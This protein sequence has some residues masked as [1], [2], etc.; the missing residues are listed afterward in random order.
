MGTL[1]ENLHVEGALSAKTMAI[2]AGTVDNADVASDADIDATKLE[3][4]YEPV[5]SQ[6]HGSAATAE[7]RV[8]HKVHG[9]TGT[10]VSF[11]CGVIVACIGNAEITID[12]Y[13]NGSTILTAPTVLDSGNTAFTE[14]SAAGFSSTALVQDDVLE[15]VVT[16]DAGTGTL[17][18]GLY[19]LPVIR[20][21][22]Q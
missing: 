21:D 12:L 19:C 1:N 16:V 8:I 11:E 9:A 3:H 10:L 2:P 15:V 4:Q 14:E 6:V 13:K 17:G 5:F 7:R 22:A 20:E 18:Q